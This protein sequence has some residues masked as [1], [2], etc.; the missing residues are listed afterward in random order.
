MATVMT[1]KRLKWLKSCQLLSKMCRKVLILK[2][3]SRSRSTSKGL[4]NPLAHQ[5]I[6]NPLVMFHLA[7]LSLT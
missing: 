7:S 3:R 4:C 6:L 1:M 5:A 2:R